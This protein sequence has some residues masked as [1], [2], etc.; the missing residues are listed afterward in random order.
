MNI[1]Y[2]RVSTDYQHTENQIQQLEKA[3]CDR[4]YTET[5]S[6]GRWDRPQLHKAL[7]DLK[8]GDC[9]VVWK[10]DR[11]SRSLSDLLHILAKLEEAGAGFKSIT[12]AIST[13]N[14][15]GRLMMHMLGSFAQFERE[16]LRER[17]KLGLARARAAGRVGGA[18]FKMSPAQQ[19]EAIRMINTGGKSQRE[20]AELFNVD[21]ST[22][23]RL[24][25]EQRVL[26]R[27]PQEHG[28]NNHL[29]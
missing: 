25:S 11:L 9:L 4:I 13:Q 23:S 1:G 19:H 8:Q 2:A 28:Q 21:P 3:D 5:A 18:R 27:K 24:I 20:V 14:A 15:A 26:T 12:E 10:L 6:G 7:G 22:I 17:T 16:M 29:Y